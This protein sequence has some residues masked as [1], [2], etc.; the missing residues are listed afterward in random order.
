MSSTYAILL[1]AKSLIE[2]IDNWCQG[3]YAL[4][5]SGLPCDIDSPDAYRW[6]ILGAIK[7]MTECEIRP[8]PAYLDAHIALCKAASELFG[9]RQTV[10]TVNDGSGTMDTPSECHAKVLA[11]YDRAIAN[12]S[13]KD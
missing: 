3:F 6:C 12:T 5:K 1:S 7:R 4:N 2:N 13:H 10:I 8:Y 9:A 11:M